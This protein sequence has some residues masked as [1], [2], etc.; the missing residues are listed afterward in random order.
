MNSP[1]KYY[2]IVYHGGDLKGLGSYGRTK[3]Y[4]THKSAEDACVR[5]TAKC[6][7]IVGGAPFYNIFLT[8]KE[9]Q[10]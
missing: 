3:S 8:M 6:L 4:K 9:D 1:S 7:K 2:G 10:K 5:L